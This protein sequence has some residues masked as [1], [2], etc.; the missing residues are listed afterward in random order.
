LSIEKETGAHVTLRAVRV[1][2]SSRILAW[3]NDPDAVRFSG[4]GRAVTAGEHRAWFS[5]VVAK[6]S[7]TRLWIAEEL[8][9]PIGQVRIDVEGD[10]GT[11]SIAVAPDR[12]GHGA[13]TAMLRA[14][15]AAAASDPTL[16]ILIALVRPDNAASLRAF[17]AAGFR[18]GALNADG[19]VQF[20]WQ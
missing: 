12:R 13:G 5:Q 11:V 8:G 15:V 19:F 7:R 20:E 10:I 17:A 3:R 14:I 2:D 18:R 16:R 9:E 1:E 4:N 6:G